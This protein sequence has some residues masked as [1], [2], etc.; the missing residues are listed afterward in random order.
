MRRMECPKTLAKAME[1]EG[2]ILMRQFPGIRHSIEVYR[3]TMELLINEVLKKMKGK[4]TKEILDELC[5]R[6]GEKDKKKSMRVAG[7]RPPLHKDVER[8]DPETDRN[9]GC[10]IGSDPP[11]P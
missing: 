1:D 2:V 3:I 11:V 7:E 8:D 4:E 5:L 9:R 6:M 10:P